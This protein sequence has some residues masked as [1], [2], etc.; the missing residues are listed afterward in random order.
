ML[1]DT[2]GVPHV[3]GPDDAT[4]FRGLGWAQARAHGRLLVRLYALARG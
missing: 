3:Y 4:V 1:W 2:W